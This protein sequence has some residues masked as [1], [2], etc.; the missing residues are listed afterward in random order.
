MIQT[1]AVPLS[2]RPT[3]EQ[4]RHASLEK[5]QQA[6]Y[7]TAEGEGF[8]KDVRNRMHLWVLKFI[9]ICRAL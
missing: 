1:N 8:S 6:D 7:A 3:T 5:S 9:P 4:D 2:F